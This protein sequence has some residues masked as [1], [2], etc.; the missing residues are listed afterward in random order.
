MT[1]RE[2]AKELY[3]KF[4]TY[5]NDYSDP[6]PAAKELSII[7]VDEIIKANPTGEYGDPFIGNKVYDN[8]SYWRE[9]KQEIEKL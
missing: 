1:P 7:A 9:V 2:K 4:S 5:V 6:E 8:K 3:L